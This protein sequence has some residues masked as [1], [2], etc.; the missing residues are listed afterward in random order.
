MRWGDGRVGVGEDGGVTT[1]SDPTLAS[2]VELIY[3]DQSRFHSLEALLLG[4]DLKRAEYSAPLWV[5][6]DSYWGRLVVPVYGARIAAARGDAQ[7]DRALLDLVEAT[8]ERFLAGE[9]LAK[10]SL[11]QWFPRLRK[12]L[13][14]DGYRMTVSRAGSG[15]LEAATR[16]RLKPTAQLPVR[17]AE[18]MA[19]LETELEVRGLQTALDHLRK[20]LAHYPR[21]RFSACEKRL[22]AALTQLTAYAAGTGDLDATRNVRHLVDTGRLT[23]ADGT[24]LLHDLRGLT[25]EDP[26]PHRNRADATRFRV[27]LTLVR[28]TALL[29][30]LEA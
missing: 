26:Y 24:R 14:V 9:S 3:G 22:R 7:A 8:V 28:A 11:P 21:E 16:C 13:L 6:A 12:A 17:L 15:G 4:V 29:A 2:V 25:S 1:L 10:K 5:N 19:L 20:A 30:Q 23:I 18:R 27:Q